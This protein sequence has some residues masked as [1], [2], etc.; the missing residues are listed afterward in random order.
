M[1]AR[2]VLRFKVHPL[3]ERIQNPYWELLREVL[4]SS[5]EFPPGST[6]LGTG[7]VL[8]NRHILSRL[9][10]LLGV[11][12]ERP[13]HA[14]AVGAVG[15]AVRCMEEG[16]T[17]VLD[18]AHIKKAL[19]VLRGRREFAPPLALSNVFRKDQDIHR[20]ASVLYLIAQRRFR[21]K[22]QAFQ[23]LNLLLRVGVGVGSSCLTTV[24]LPF[25][26]PAVICPPP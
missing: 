12:I 16:S 1:L 7:G 3:V 6:V 19:A 20:A 11:R 4:F 23:Q 21:F 15:A 22:A 18:L 13:P 2:E 5:V 24:I 10:Q 17:F 14:A 9:Q 25:W 26:S 8:A